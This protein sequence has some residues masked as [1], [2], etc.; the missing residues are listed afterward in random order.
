MTEHDALRAARDELARTS[1]RLW[2]QT[3]SQLPSLTRTTS[4]WPQSSQMAVSACCAQKSISGWKQHGFGPERTNGM[5]KHD[6]FA[7]GTKLMRLG[8]RP[9]LTQFQRDEALRL[10]E[11]GETQSD[12]AR[13]LNISQSTISRLAAP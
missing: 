13:L 4:L 2:R 8:R 10:L 3:R 5:S 12:V 6:E 9:K 1:L 7:L 11:M